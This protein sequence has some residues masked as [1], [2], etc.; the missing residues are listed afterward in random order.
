MRDK[1]VPISSSSGRNTAFNIRSNSSTPADPVPADEGGG[2]GEPERRGAPPLPPTRPPG[3]G[4]PPIGVGT[5]AVSTSASA[6]GSARSSSSSSSS[7]PLSGSPYS[8]SM[9]DLH[10]A[11]SSSVVRPRPSRFFTGRRPS[12]FLQACHLG[13]DMRSGRGTLPSA[14]HSDKVTSSFSPATSLLIARGDYPSP[15]A[16]PNQPFA[17]SVDRSQT[18]N[19]SQRFPRTA[20]NCGRELSDL[21][22]HTPQSR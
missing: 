10:K 6:S 17:A 20:P 14:M 12:S 1:Y 9:I 19:Q 16:L 7:S 18:G 4:S 5:K 15:P 3:P 22:T 11:T 13:K 21:R 2:L 8:S